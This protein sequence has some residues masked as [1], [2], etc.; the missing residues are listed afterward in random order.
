MAASCRQA[1]CIF[2]ASPPLNM[3]ESHQRARGR[4]VVHTPTSLIRT[5]QWPRY[6]NPV[7]SASNYAAGPGERSGARVPW[8]HASAKGQPRGRHAACLLSRGLCVF[9]RGPPRLTTY[10]FPWRHVQRQQKSGRDQSPKVKYE[11][12]DPEHNLSMTYESCGEEG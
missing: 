2:P 4:H 1:M 7:D 8:N 10:Q 5:K 6:S 12:H 3:D 9:A 11:F